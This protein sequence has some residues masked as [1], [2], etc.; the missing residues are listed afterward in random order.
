MAMTQAVIQEVLDMLEA[1]VATDGGS[2]RIAKFVEADSRLVIDYAKGVND[3]CATCV[4]DAES[5]RAFVVE[6]VSA[7]GISL[8]DVT[9]IESVS[10]TA[11][12]T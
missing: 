1:M 9:I 10:T 12:A 8:G 11:S 5:L 3:A 6:G 7:R 2:I 4:I